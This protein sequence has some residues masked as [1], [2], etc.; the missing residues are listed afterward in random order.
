MTDRGCLGRC[1]QW[2]LLADPRQ[3]HPRLQENDRQ[4]N[5]SA[6]FINLVG[7]REMVRGEYLRNTSHIGIYYTVLLRLNELSLT[8]K[9]DTAEN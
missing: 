9:T 4:E 7:F 8:L 1:R 6:Q 5:W 3:D 2:H